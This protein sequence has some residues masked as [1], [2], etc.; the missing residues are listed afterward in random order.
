MAAITYRPKKYLKTC[1]QPSW[2][3]DAGL[4]LGARLKPKPSK[5]PHPAS[6]P[7]GLRVMACWMVAYPQAISY[8]EKA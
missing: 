5:T 7:A 3:A 4:S 2:R 6:L 8:I 1:A